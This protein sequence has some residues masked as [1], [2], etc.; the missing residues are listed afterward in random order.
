MFTT[1]QLHAEDSVAEVVLDRTPVNAVS[2]RMYE[3]LTAAFRELSARTDV[4][5]VILRSANPRMFCAGADIR[6]TVEAVSPAE[7]VFELR[8]RW[9]RTCY[10]AILDCAVPTIAVVNGHALGAGA[11][12]AGCCD[13]RFAAADLSIG[14]PEI[15][16]GRCGGARHLGRLIPQG[17]LRMLYFTGEPLDAEEALR[18][19]LVQYVGKNGDELEQARTLAAKIARKSPL[20]LRL[21]KR[22]LNE[23]EAM[24][25]REG[26]AHE[27]KYTIRLAQ[28]PDAQEAASA[29]L[30]KREAR[31]SWPSNGFSVASTEAAP[32][33]H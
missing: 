31:W 30:E 16:A 19:D 2:L 5:A 28:S 18:L 1:I 10:E 32:L 25:V 9:A 20:G 7:S 14:L 26:Y 12:L 15:N 4:H 33:V 21:A 11:V 27:Q 23:S 22:A 13:I 24:G 8:Q 17:R 3:E 6:E 29:T